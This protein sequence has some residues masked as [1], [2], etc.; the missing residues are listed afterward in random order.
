MGAVLQEIEVEE[1]EEVQEIEDQELT[2]P[3][4]EFRILYCG[5]ASREF[6][7]FIYLLCL[8]SIL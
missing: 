7:Y 4:I 5:T 2:H 3:T 1:V 8:L 6:L